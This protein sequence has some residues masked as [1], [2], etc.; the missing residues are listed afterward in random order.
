ML[1]YDSR[2]PFNRHPILITKAFNFGWSNRIAIQMMHCLLILVCSSLFPKRF[3]FNMVSLVQICECECT[4]VL[5]MRACV[6]AEVDECVY[7]GSPSICFATDN[8]LCQFCCLL[9]L[10]TLRSFRLFPFFFFP[11]SLS[12]LRAHVICCLR[13]FPL[14]HAVDWFVGWWLD[15]WQAKIDSFQPPMVPFLW[16]AHTFILTVSVIWGFVDAV[17][18]C[19]YLVLGT[20]KYA[21]NEHWTDTVIRSLYRRTLS[22]K[23]RKQKKRFVMGNFVSICDSPDENI[24]SILWISAETNILI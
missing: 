1:L 3:L 17:V 24:Y 11:L 8:S 16:G 5:C 4:C 22:G 12:A 21:R 10:F 6:R 18:V 13:W 7:F 9:I 15:G 14:S 2:H 23:G 20:R 19:C